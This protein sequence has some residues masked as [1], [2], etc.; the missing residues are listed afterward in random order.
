LTELGGEE[1]HEDVAAGSG[2][3]AHRPGVAGW[4]YLAVSRQDPIVLDPTGEA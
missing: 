4:G 1:D 2:G 3:D